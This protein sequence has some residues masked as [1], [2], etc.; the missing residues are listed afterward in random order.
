MKQTA[1]DPK[2]KNVVQTSCGYSFV[3]TT[4]TRAYKTCILAIKTQQTWH[5]N[6]QRTA[7]T[8]CHCMRIIP[9]S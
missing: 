3:A 5:N 7:H 9:V 4:N 8:H 1:K 2:K 6:R